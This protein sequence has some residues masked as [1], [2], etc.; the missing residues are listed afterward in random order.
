MEW[1]ELVLSA[2]LLSANIV[3]FEHEE[4][5]YLFITFKSIGIAV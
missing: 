5:H 2:K 3:V 4:P 1:N